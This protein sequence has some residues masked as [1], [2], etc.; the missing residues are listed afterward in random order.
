MLFKHLIVAS[1][2]LLPFSLAAET[3]LYACTIKGQTT[4][5]STASKNCDTLQT[6]TYPTYNK[7]EKQPSAPNVAAKEEAANNA[8]APSSSLRPE[9]VRQLQALEY[10][11]INSQSLTRRFENVD[12]RVGWSLAGQYID[13][14]QDKCSYFLGVLDHSLSYIEMKRAQDLEIGPTDSARLRVQIQYAQ[15]QVNYYCR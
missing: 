12:E 11:P 9:E 3:T 10:S 6:Y 2:Y 14:R 13:S 5:E 4:L 7:A 15:D 1:L 8:P